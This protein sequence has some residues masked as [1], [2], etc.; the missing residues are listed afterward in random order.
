MK[1]KNNSLQFIII[2]VIT[3][4]IVVMFIMAV[5]HFIKLDT[6]NYSVSKIV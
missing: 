1:K 4:L 2:T 5:N 6:N 3:F